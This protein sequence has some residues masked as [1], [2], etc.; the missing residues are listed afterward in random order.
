MA[1][2]IERTDTVMGKLS[3]LVLDQLEADLAAERALADEGA[4]V[5]SRVVV[6]WKAQTG[7]DLAEHPDVIAF[8]ARYRKARQ[9]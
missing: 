5:L 4:E 7:I 1:T 2:D 9:R 8:F 6:G 3:H